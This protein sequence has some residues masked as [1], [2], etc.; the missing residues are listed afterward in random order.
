MLHDQGKSVGQRE[1]VVN[2]SISDLLV[3]MSLLR[4]E[5]GATLTPSCQKQT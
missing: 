3:A 4:D 2:E 5:A 1:V